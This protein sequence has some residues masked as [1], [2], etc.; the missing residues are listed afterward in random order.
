MKLNEYYVCDSDGNIVEKD[1]KANDIY[2]TCSN[3]M[4]LPSGL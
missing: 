4:E 3:Q 1:Y 2:S